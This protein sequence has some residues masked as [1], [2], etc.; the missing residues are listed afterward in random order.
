MIDLIAIFYSDR[1]EMS[2]AIVKEDGVED[3]LLGPVPY[4]NAVTALAPQ[5]AEYLPD[6]FTKE[7]AT[8]HLMVLHFKNMTARVNSSGQSY[9]WVMS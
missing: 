3:K 7:T 1:K 5:L 4:L 8:H 9:P 6:K 2:L